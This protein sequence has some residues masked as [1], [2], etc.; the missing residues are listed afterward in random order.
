MEH[1]LRIILIEL[2]DFMI[3][4]ELTFVATAGD[5]N[6]VCINHYNGVSFDEVQFD[7]EINALDLR[8][9]AKE[10]K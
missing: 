6:R 1:S 10:D 4:N 3:E 5:E 7:E 2:A 9:K 8:N